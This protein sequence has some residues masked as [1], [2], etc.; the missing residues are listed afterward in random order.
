MSDPAETTA[1][2]ADAAELRLV[3]RLRAKDEAAFMEIVDAWGPSMLRLARHD[4]L[5]P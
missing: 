4:S 5:G 3:E 2:Q 1:P